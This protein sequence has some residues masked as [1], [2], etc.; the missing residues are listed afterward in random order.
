MSRVEAV[1]FSVPTGDA[2]LT[3]GLLA[4]SA[5]DDT[6]AALLERWRAGATLQ[7]VLLDGKGHGYGGTPFSEGACSFTHPGL[8]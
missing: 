2:N 5:A 4:G 6:A 7:T 3:G 1:L 8:L